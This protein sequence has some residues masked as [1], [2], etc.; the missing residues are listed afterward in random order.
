MNIITETLLTYWTAGRKTKKTPS[1]WITG[2]APCCQDSRQRGGFIVT[3]EEAVSY[4]C[5]NCQFKTSFTVGRHI[6]HKMRQFMHY[7]NIPDS[8]INK[9]I[10]AAL[11]LETIESSGIDIQ[12]IP[13]FDPKPLPLGANPIIDYL[14]NIPD[15]LIPVLEYMAER[16]L[17]LDDYPFHWT[18]K[19]GM[20]NRIIIPFYYENNTVG[21]TARIITKTSV[22]RYYSDQHPNYVFNL[23]RQTENRSSVIVCEG[24]FDAISIDGCAL[25]G[26]E[27]RS[28]HDWLLK[29]LNRE[30]ILVPDKDSKGASMIE[31]AIE[32]N[33]SVSM[34]DWPDNVK[35]INDAVIKLGR[36]STLWLILNA[37]ETYPLKIRLRAK[38]FFKKETT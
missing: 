25:L 15:K 37:K 13:K 8:E 12:M 5:F 2:N 1:G 27:I 35:D 30:I 16:K 28:Q 23:D 31:Q 32:F 26:S 29:R 10:L 14:D 38:K 11:Q 18:P 24:P 36:L 4:H 21:Y 19:T 7:L 9:L 34:P 33:W 3:P 20:N 17:C 22:N 6:T